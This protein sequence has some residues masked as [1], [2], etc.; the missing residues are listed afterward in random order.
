MQILTFDEAARS[1]LMELLDA[2]SEAHNTMRCDEVQGFMM[3]LL[4]GPDALN[5]TNWLPEILGEESL[6]DAKERTEIERLVM[7][8][9]AD[10]RMKLNEKILPDLWFYEDEAGNP[11]FYTWCN[12][13]LYALDIVPTDWFEAVDQEEFEDLFYPI[14]ALGGI[15]DDEENG[16]VILHLNEK[17]LT[18][19]ESDLPHVLL[20]IYWYW[21][22]IINKPQTV[23]REGEKVGR[24]DPCP[25]GSGK[26]YKA[27]CGK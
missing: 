9:A 7:A 21:Q 13:Y 6:F 23:R 18:Q 2:K 1:R 20:D 19:L 25:C 3:A 27:C 11:D 5:P 14:M 24:N 26:K 4:S 17:E 8:M 10:M 22:A 12:A 15:Y 16:E